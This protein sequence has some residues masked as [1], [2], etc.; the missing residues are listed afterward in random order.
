M[1]QRMCD[2]CG[3]EMT[4]QEY[5]KKNALIEGKVYCNK[6]KPK[7]DNIVGGLQPEKSSRKNAVET[8]YNTEKERLIA[9]QCPK[10]I[11]GAKIELSEGGING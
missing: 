7:V 4:Q 11:A 2:G 1:I 5:E 8:W 3:T 6:C 9:E 10:A